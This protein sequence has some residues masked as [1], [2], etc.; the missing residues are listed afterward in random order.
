MTPLRS[1]LPT[2]AEFLGAHG[3]AT[4][5]FVANVVYCSYDTGLDRG[6]THYED[7]V[8]DGPTAMRTAGLVNYSLRIL[9]ELSRGSDQGSLGFLRD[10]VN[11]WTSP[12]GTQG[13]RVEKPRVS[14]LVVK[15]SR[16]RASLLCLSQFHRRSCSVRPAPRGTPSFRQRAPDIGRSARRLRPLAA[17]RQDEVTPKPYQSGRD[18]YDDCLGYLDDQLGLLFDEL[19]R[20]NLLEKTLV[21]VTSDHGEGLGEHDLFDHG[22][23]LYRTEI[24]VPLVIVPPQGRQA[25]AVVRQPVSLR[26]LAA[27]IVDLVG[28]NDRSP[29][30]G[31][32]LAPLWQDPSAGTGSDS[33]DPVISELAAPNPI[34]PNQGR[35]PAR[36][37]PLI[38]VTDGDFV[39]IRNQKDGSEQLY[40]EHDD[41][42]ELSDRSAADAYQPILQR[43]RLRLAAFQNRSSGG[44]K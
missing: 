3:Y 28:L 10:A 13:C 37:G 20:R 38:A 19:R 35:S 6:F 30:P 4:A 22:E 9:E 29:F 8:L 44:A 2:L 43:F 42:R 36:R 40:N 15:P 33:N 11:R 32:S 41:P 1:N 25:Q 26:N 27:T 18:S 12:T 24:R 34:D 17:P 21:I 5:G 31:R 39:Y 7:Y 23:S 14:R 16:N